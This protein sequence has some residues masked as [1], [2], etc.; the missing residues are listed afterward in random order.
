MAFILKESTTVWCI[1]FEIAVVVNIMNSTDTKQYLISATVCF[2]YYFIFAIALTFNLLTFNS[3]FGY[4]TVLVFMFYIEEMSLK[5]QCKDIRYVLSCHEDEELLCGHGDIYMTYF[6]FYH[7]LQLKL[8]SRVHPAYTSLI[9]SYQVLHSLTNL[10]ME[11]SFFFINST[12]KLYVRPVPL[13]ALSSTYLMQSHRF[14]IKT[15]YGSQLF[16]WLNIHSYTENEMTSISLFDGPILVNTSFLYEM[17]RFKYFGGFA[18]TLGVD[19]LNSVMPT[20]DRFDIKFYRL[21]ANMTDVD[22]S[23]NHAYNISLNTW[24]RDTILYYKHLR[25]KNTDNDFVKISFTNIRTYSGSSYNCEYG[26]FVLSD[27][28]DLHVSVYGPYCTQHGMEPLVNEVSTFHSK[29]TYLVLIV[30]SYTFQL[31]VDISFQ[32][33]SCEGLTNICDVYCGP[34]SSVHMLHNKGTNYEVQGVKYDKNVCFVSLHITKGCLMIQEL[35][36]R[37]TDACIVNLFTRS[38]VLGTL[39]YMQSSFR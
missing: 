22:I 29:N 24:N 15:Y 14:T 26:G 7:Q 9:L 38:G 33:A 30:Y 35:S 37:M 8:E 34:V 39:L 21:T 25:V 17:E 13:R 16:V 12:R 27:I 10:W 31:D 28:W 2:Y 11:E 18:V 20:E 19:I 3:S 23:N 32:S 36:T 5:R 4:L 6:C 1:A